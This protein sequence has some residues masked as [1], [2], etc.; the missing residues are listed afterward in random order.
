M[1]ETRIIVGGNIMKGRLY[2][3]IDT[4]RS[5]YLRPEWYN[6]TVYIGQPL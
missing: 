4:K 1:F 3:N 2:T 5:S 6:G